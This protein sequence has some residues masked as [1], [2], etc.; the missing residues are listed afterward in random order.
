MYC[1]DYSHCQECEEKGNIEQG[2]ISLTHPHVMYKVH[3]RAKNLD[4]I[5]IGKQIFPTPKEITTK[6]GDL[7]HWCGCDGR[8][9]PET[10][11]CDGSVEGTR[12]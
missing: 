12:Y 5:R 11:D 7:T 8:Y 1:E 4:K 3:P 2:T 10:L 9:D 6:P